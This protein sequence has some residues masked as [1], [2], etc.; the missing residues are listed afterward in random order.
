MCPG[1][2]C[3]VCDVKCMFTECAESISRDVVRGAQPLRCEYRVGST[4]TKHINR[5]INFLLWL[6]LFI[7]RLWVWES[8][9]VVWILMRNQMKV[10]LRNQQFGSTKSTNNNSKT[11][12]RLLRYWCK[13][14]HNTKPRCSRKFGTIRLG[15]NSGR[16]KKPKQQQKSKRWEEDNSKTVCRILR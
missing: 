3:L 5:S 14:V 1:G 13:S 12:C 9:D 10:E 7:P 8:W 16:E 4:C 2:V 6:D 15:Q 11:A